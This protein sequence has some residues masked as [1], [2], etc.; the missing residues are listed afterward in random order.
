MNRYLFL[1][2]ASFFSAASLT[3]QNVT[4]DIDPPIRQMM[5]HYIETNKA[6]PFVEGWRI[7]I[8]ATTD[9]QK[10]ESA[11]RNF[12]YRYPNIA[13]DW[14]HAEP[15][16]KLRAGAFE[17]KMEATRMLYILKRDFPGAY[18]VVDNEIKPEEII[19]L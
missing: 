2:L 9:R 10:L 3:G 12:R 6:N 19:G 17:T 11:M 14:V 8:L 5:D 18:R 7:Q 15:Y 16:F 13:V 1:F 4:L